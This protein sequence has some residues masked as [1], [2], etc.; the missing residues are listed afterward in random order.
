MVAN[1]EDIAAL[2]MYTL[3]SDLSTTWTSF[4][5]RIPETVC[6]KN[7]ATATYGVRL[8][9]SLYGWKDNFITFPTPPNSSPSSEL[10][11]INKTSQHPESV[12]VLHHLFWANGPCIVSGLQPML[13]APPWSRPNPR[14]PGS[15]INSVA[16]T[17]WTWVLFSSCVFLRETKIASL[18]L[19]WQ[20]LIHWSRAP[21]LALLDFVD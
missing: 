21:I 8:R 20:V 19:W 12:R 18:Y 2:D 5:S 13:W 11:E 1:D 9:I 3:K 4:P 10:T 14:S 17:V 7:D 16:A 6:T 15:S